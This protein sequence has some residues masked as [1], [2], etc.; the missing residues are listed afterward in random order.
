MYDE[1]EDG[2]EEGDDDGLVENGRIDDGIRVDE[3]DVKEAM[4]A[5]RER[6][7]VEDAEEEDEQ[8]DEQ[9]EG[10]EEQV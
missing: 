9:E 4:A 5:I 6:V 3:E 1:Y 2:A 8:E 10:Q 7:F